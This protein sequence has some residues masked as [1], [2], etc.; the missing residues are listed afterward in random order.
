MNRMNE[1]LKT[2]MELQDGSIRYN[3]VTWYSV[4][5][6]VMGQKVLF[7]AKTFGSSTKSTY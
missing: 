5:I 1:I 6:E 4:D 2:K 3:G 7:H